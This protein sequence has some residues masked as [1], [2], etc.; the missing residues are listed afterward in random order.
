MLR[1]VF[2]GSE[3]S[4]LHKYS[5]RSF[6]SQS[7]FEKAQADLK[8]LPE[9]PDV[10]AKLKI[11]GLFKQAMMGDVSGKRPGALDFAGRAK[12]DSWQSFQG[13]SKEDAQKQYAD[14]VNS[15]LKEANISADASGTSSPSAESG[16]ETPGLKVYKQD[17]VFRI[18]LARASKFNAITWDMYEGI[19]KAL[20]EA[21]KDRTT[22]ITLITGHGDYYC[23]GNDLQNFTRVDVSSREGMLK[24]AETA[25]QILERFVKAFIEHEKPLVS[26]VNGP[27]IGISVTL[28]PMF[29]LVIAS[30][31]ASFHTPFSSLGQS[32]EGCSSYTFPALM[33]VTKAAEMLIF[34]KKVSA[35]EALERNLV[36]QVIPH[37]QFHKEAEE[38]IVKLSQLPPE[39]LRLNKCL[40]RS[41]HK[42]DLLKVNVA[43][44]RL[45]ETRW[46]SS[47][48]LQALQKFAG[49]RK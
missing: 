48:C 20:D 24:M 8:K 30:D 31:K 1:N 36:T 3:R 18:E 5:I 47:E 33:G 17:K 26:L 21:S 19:I 41:S 45:I 22:S 11:Y 29:D 28:L 2:K 27:A 10:G 6:S 49:R 4:L 16:Q 7:D 13:I 32:P 12:F 35:L 44:C 25:G 43:E 39:S 14:L 15:L 34:D 9:E 38:R 40:L 23:S 37:G 46:V 42:E